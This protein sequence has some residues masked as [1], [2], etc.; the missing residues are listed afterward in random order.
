MD[1]VRYTR[2][3]LRLTLWIESK[4]W[5][6]TQSGKGQ[7]AVDV[8]V[9]DFASNALLRRHKKLLRRGRGLAGLDDET[10]HRARIAA[11]KVRYA[12][13]FFASLF[14]RSVVKHSIDALSELQEDL[15]WRND[16]VVASGL[17]SRSPHLIRSVHQVL[18]S[19]ADISH[20]VPPQ[21]MSR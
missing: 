15:G 6:D 21:T 11:K 9:L 2:L 18:V 16:I 13:E 4:G 10:R 8:P 17:S 1:S 12:T 7:A 5:R 19:R 3:M 14:P 20:P